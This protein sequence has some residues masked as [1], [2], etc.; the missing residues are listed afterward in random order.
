MREFAAAL[1]GQR[2]EREANF[3]PGI[4][5]PVDVEV[6]EE[7]QVSSGWLGAGGGVLRR[8]GSEGAVLDLLGGVCGGFE[9]GSIA[10]FS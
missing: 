4:I 2:R 10:L 8:G 1:G 5:A 7:D 3:A 6:L 9:R